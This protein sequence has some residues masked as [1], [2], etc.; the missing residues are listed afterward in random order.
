MIEVRSIVPG[1]SNQAF[2]RDYW[3]KRPLHIKGGASHILRE[4]L[5]KREFLLIC[6]DLNKLEQP[7]VRHYSSGTLHAQ[8]IDRVR[9]SFREI[10]QEIRQTW[11][12]QHVWFDGSLSLEGSGIGSHFD[13]SD[14]FILQ[15]SGRRMWRLHAPDI[16]PDRTKR[17]RCLGIVTDASI[18]MPENHMVFELEPGDLL[19]IPLLWIHEGITTQESVSLSLAFP[20]DS[21]L[22]IFINILRRELTTERLWWSPVPIAPHGDCEATINLEGETDA[23]FEQLLSSLH[24]PRMQ[25]RLKA[26]WWRL[27]R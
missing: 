10:S 11:R 13:I 6:D 7:M 19:Y 23:Y 15:Q 4:V 21:P 3:R 8:N 27:L 9:A 12:T 26:A 17:D 18:D 5:T 16:I 24:S 2:Y 1:I 22:D 25:K 20:I 14:N